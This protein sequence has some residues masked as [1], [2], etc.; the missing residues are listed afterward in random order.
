MHPDSKMLPVLLWVSSYIM[1]LVSIYGIGFTS[2]S[3]TVMGI[4]MAESVNV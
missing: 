4:L 2:G 1:V 3:R